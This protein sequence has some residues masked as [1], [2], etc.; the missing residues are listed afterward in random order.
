MR[1]RPNYLQG[2]AFG[3]A[4]ASIWAGWSPI[5]RLGVTTQLNAWDVAILRFGVAG[6]LLLPVVLQRGLALD[7]I[8][9]RGLALMI[10]GGGVP[11]VLLAATGLAFAPAHD[12]AALNP[13]T[14][15]LFVALIA[16]IAVGEKLTALRKLGLA[17][18]AAGAVVIVGWYVA[19]WSMSRTLGHMLGLAAAF[20]WACFTVIMSNGKVDSLHAAALVATGSLLIYLPIYLAMFGTR[21]ML[22]AAPDLAVQTIYQGI[23]VSIVS[24][25]FYGSAMDI[26]GTSGGAAFGAL[27]PAM[28]GLFAIPL[29]GE[30][31]NATDWFGM[32]LVSAGVY[33]TSGGPV[34]RTTQQGG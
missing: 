33:L 5:T 3:L 26:L 1:P 29:L 17:L 32:L 6:V 12:Q 31:P 10:F 9:W 11:Y 21:L 2:A 18:I 28:T 16:H 4:A 20:L 23:L 30:W 22:V 27:V 14:V 34:P 25:V 8:G 7:R 15:P 19:S 24:L 13:G